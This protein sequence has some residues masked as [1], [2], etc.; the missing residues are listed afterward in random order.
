MSKNRTEESPIIDNSLSK[1]K[2]FIYST[3]FIFAGGFLGLGID[4]LFV[5]KVNADD[6]CVSEYEFINPEP[7]CETYSEKA[8]QLANLQSELEKRVK[9]FEKTPGVKRVAVF[10][11]DMVTQRFVGVNENEYFYMASLLKVPLVIGWYKLAE[12]EPGVLDKKIIYKGDPDLYNEQNIPPNEKLQVGRVYSMKELISSAIIYSDNTAAQI[13]LD[14][15]PKN[16]ID[17]I[18]AALSLQFK[19]PDGVYENIITAKSYANVFRVLYNSS[20][21]TREYSN[22]ALNVLTKSTY[23]DGIL[24][25]S[26][27]DK[28]AHKFGERTT[29]YPDGLEVKQLHECGLVYANKGKEPFT[30]C[31]MTEGNDYNQLKMVIQETAKTIY[32]GISG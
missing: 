27:K 29:L 20:Y 23:S 2:I 9:S 28:V 1:K 24:A 3:L 17:R 14:N 22:E 7:D 6:D 10:S 26:G 31:I 12:V 8:Q 13:L 16:F 32:K 11:R 15:L 18:L 30:F 4:R 19:G 21:L 25:V 5:H